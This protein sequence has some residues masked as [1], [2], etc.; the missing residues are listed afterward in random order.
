MT[1]S[2]GTQATVE[3]ASSALAES[4]GFTRPGRQVK[5]LTVIDS[6]GWVWVKSEDGSLESYPPQVV[7]CVR[8]QGEPPEPDAT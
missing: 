2:V 7:A 8:W 1:W 4:S 6:R 3:L 5:G